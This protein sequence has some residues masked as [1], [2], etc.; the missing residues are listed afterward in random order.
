MSLKHPL[1]RFQLQVFGVYMEMA[2]D[3]QESLVNSQ[4]QEM[5]LH[6]QEMVMAGRAVL[7]MVLEH[8]NLD[9]A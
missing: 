8:R 1:A 6:S 7:V 4:D 5:V 3:F 9:L 2:Y